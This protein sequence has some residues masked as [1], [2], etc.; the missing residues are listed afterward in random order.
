MITRCGVTPADTDLPSILEPK[1]LG[2]LVRPPT[3]A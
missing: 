2:L 1:A 3:P